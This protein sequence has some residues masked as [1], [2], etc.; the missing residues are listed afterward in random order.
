MSLEEDR[1]NRAQ[2]GLQGAGSDS[3]RKFWAAMA[4]YAVLAGLAWFT[5]GEG[6]IFVGGKPVELRILPLLILG[7][8]ALRTVLARQ[9][10]K[11][12]R[13]GD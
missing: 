4:V 2:K 7:G 6:S 8:L 11:I 12:R 1:L 13:G 5:L 9:A 10:D 3:D